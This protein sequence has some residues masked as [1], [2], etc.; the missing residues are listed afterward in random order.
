LAR[1]A[2]KAVPLAGTVGKLAGIAGLAASA[3]KPVRD[4]GVR[5]LYNAA[6]PY[7]GETGRTA[8]AAV[9]KGLSTVIPG[10]D[11]HSTDMLE[12][13]R[14]PTEA[15]D[16]LSSRPGKYIGE[17]IANQGGAVIGAVQGLS[18]IAD[19]ASTSVGDYIRGAVRGT[20]HPLEDL[21]TPFRD[22]SYALA[23]PVVKGAEKTPDGTIT[24]TMVEGKAEPEFITTSTPNATGGTDER[25]VKNPKYAMGIKPQI[26]LFSG[27]GAPSR[28]GQSPIA[29]AAKLGD[30]YGAPVYQQVMQ[31]PNAGYDDMIG[32]QMDILNRGPLSNNFSDL[33]RYKHESRNAQTAL[34]TLQKLKAGKEGL[35]AGQSNKQAELGDA[36][37]ARSQASHDKSLDRDTE[38]NRQAVE[39]ARLA[40]ST[41]YSRGRDAQADAAATQNAK[42]K[43]QQYADEQATKV[44]ELSG[45]VSTRTNP[46]TGEDFKGTE[47]EF[48]A[49]M[50]GFMGDKAVKDR[51]EAEPDLAPEDQQN[52][53]D[54]AAFK[55]LSSQQA[56]KPKVALTPENKAKAIEQLHALGTTDPNRASE[57]LA[58]LQ[59][60]FP[61]EF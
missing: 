55:Y 51:L 5:P 54:E 38:A 32:Q 19:R 18:S 42:M 44:K 46:A 49:A 17:G 25:R 41:Q 15:A 2:A 4:L 26:P 20:E 40:D 57:Y 43:A 10:E 58:K 47:A 52:I 21:T 35:M 50:P 6:S 53:R 12:G 30:N 13:K 33:I 24:K 56:P 22:S 37:N 3:V 27:K 34:D 36:V 9:D 39:D 23:E 1:G 28:G 11:T 48:K 16:Q 59:A 61:G 60:Q 7:L 45:K 8:F 14:V 29:P 31:N